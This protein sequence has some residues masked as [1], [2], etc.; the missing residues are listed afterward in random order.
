[1]DKKLEELEAELFATARRMKPNEFRNFLIAEKQFQD[2]SLPLASIKWPSWL[3]LYNTSKVLARQYKP[4][5][6]GYIFLNALLRVTSIRANDQPIPSQQD[7]N[8]LAHCELCWRFAP[9]TGKYHYCRKHRPGGGGQK[10]Y[11]RAHRKLPLFQSEYRKLMERLRG[12]GRQALYV[13]ETDSALTTWLTRFYPRVYEYIGRP[14]NL[15]IEAILYQLDTQDNRRERTEL[16]RH[17]VRNRDEATSI[18]RQA[19]AWFSTM[20]IDNRGDA[21]R[22]T[23]P[24]RKIDI[25]KAHELRAKGYSLSEIG[26]HFGVTRQAVYKSLLTHL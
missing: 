3:K 10:D 18:I 17:I 24:S 4:A 22:L 12:Y 1:M 21:N 8:N 15:T 20:E 26:R 2:F 9:S 7:W 14:S 5:S 11:R 25:G 23:P 16:H 13:P 6:P 19:E